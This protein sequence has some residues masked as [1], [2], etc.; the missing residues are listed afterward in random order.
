MYKDE[1][2]CMNRIVRI[3]GSPFFYLT[4]LCLFFSLPGSAQ[5]IGLVSIRGEGVPSYLLK[6]GEG[7]A[8]D[9]IR[10]YTGG[11]VLAGEELQKKREAEGLTAAEIA[12]CDDP[13][14]ARDLAGRLGLDGIAVFSL[15][16]SGGGYILS[17]QGISADGARKGRAEEFFIDIRNYDATVAEVG[18]NLAV[19]M[20]LAEAVIARGPD[21]EPSVPEEEI[22]E[23]TAE[24][25]SAD[26]AGELSGGE[27]AGD[28]PAESET[29]E[30]VLQDTEPAAP[31]QTSTG[32]RLFTTGIALYQLGGLANMLTLMSGA[33]S[34]SSDYLAR[35]AL[36]PADR[37]SYGTAEDFYRAAR[38]I[39]S[40]AAWTMHAAAP[41]TAG[42][43]LIGGDAGDLK[44]SYRGKWYLYAGIGTA[45]A[46][47]LL[48]LDSIDPLAESSYLRARGHSDT[49]Y[50][51]EYDRE[52]PWV[53]A[54]QGMVLGL[55]TLGSA[56]VLAAPAQ[57]GD[58][59]ALASNFWDRVLVGSGL[60]LFSGGNVF[61]SLAGIGRTDSLADWYRYQEVSSPA[62]YSAWENSFDSFE[63]KRNL[64]L[65]F[66]L[67]GAFCLALAELTDFPDPF[68]S[69]AASAK[70][71]SETGDFPLVSLRFLPRPDGGSLYF[72]LSFQ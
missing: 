6:V 17:L 20:G 28:V 47:H 51:E 8:G 25:P 58:R 49:Y 70:E 46:G 27:E 40:T 10:E 57:P 66:W 54:R 48:Y 65:G 72:H 43:P 62:R 50:D 59:E 29:S 5:E 7:L 37:D 64:A 12:G 55:W 36:L 18:E 19:Q 9:T 71:S 45:L 44:F 3:G 31:V 15:E 56:A 34:V 63:L 60:A 35:N 24:A 16:R 61:A 23:D 69:G 4:L 52:F 22:P 38:T 42:F 33:E 67:G 32:E 41:V 11:R 68:E 30:T 39:S 13:E 1:G 26:S 14:C 21:Q 2:G 53:L